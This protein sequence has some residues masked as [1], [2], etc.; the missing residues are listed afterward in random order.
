MSPSLL[1]AATGC[2]TMRAALYAAPLAATMDR[3]S[4]STP[5]RRAAFL[6]QLA[7]ESALFSRV[8]E[9]LFYSAKRLTQV[10]PTRFP[11]LAA[12]A[13]FAHNPVALANKVYGGRMGN[14]APGDGYRYR[15]RGLIQLTGYDNYKA[16][17]EAS[18][19]AVLTYPDLVTEP[20]YSADSAGWF[21]HSRGCNSFADR[22][23]YAGL[24]RRIN[25][26][27]TGLQD[28]I[29]AINRAKAALL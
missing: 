8:E 7:H 23:D 4:I 20:R 24:T 27:L 10:F 28:R 22:E 6:G 13:P 12:A 1:A 21:W 29:C 17:G 11:D 26:G 15:G 18:C 5:L 9:D 14:T 19:T 2:T 3:W 16:Y 25:G